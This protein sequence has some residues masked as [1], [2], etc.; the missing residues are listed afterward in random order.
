MLCALI[1]TLTLFL[2]A[3][4]AVFLFVQ[5]APLMAA[6]VLAS[7]VITFTVVLTL[8]RIADAADIIA[9]NTRSK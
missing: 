9:Q 6:A 3:C 2:S 1:A 5:D 8:G 4:A 7:G